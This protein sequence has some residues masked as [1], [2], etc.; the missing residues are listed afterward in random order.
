MRQY[1]QLTREQRYCSY[2]LKQAGLSNRAIAGKI[3]VHHPTVSR[4][5]KRNTRAGYKVYRSGTAHWLALER[6]QSSRKPVVLTSKNSHLV[7]DK[8]KKHWS[9]EQIS[10]WLKLHG[11]ISVNQE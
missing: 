1:K 5:L 9:P 3:N 6:R 8:L 10:G 11:K 4:E 7:I 2:V